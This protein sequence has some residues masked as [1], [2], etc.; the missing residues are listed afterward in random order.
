[1]QNFVLIVLIRA[2]VLDERT[3]G[4]GGGLFL[5]YLQKISKCKEV[6]CTSLK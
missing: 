1:M 2:L 5:I 6:L 4:G 3:L